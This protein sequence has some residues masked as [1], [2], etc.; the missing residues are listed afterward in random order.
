MHSS[1]EKIYVGQGVKV[2]ARFRDPETLEP[3]DPVTVMIK[4]RGPD[5]AVIDGEA[6]KSEDG[7]YYGRAVVDAKGI[8]V[9]VVSSS[10][11]GAAVDQYEFNVVEPAIMAV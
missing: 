7:V 6:E 5:G 10:D 9:C 4:F 11:P 3:V 2:R 1:K 8:W